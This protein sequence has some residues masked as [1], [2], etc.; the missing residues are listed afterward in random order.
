MSN[1]TIG[2]EQ[3]AMDEFPSYKHN[4]VHKVLLKLFI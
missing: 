1:K 2:L 3:G 4:E